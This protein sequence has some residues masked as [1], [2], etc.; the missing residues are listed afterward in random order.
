M[1]SG[2]LTSRQAVETNSN[3]CGLHREAAGQAAQHGLNRIASGFLAVDVYLLVQ[4]HR[5]K[6]HTALCKR[7]M[8]ISELLMNSV[9]S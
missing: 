6:V 9:L 5:L 1:I 3:S 8:W 4:L 7:K 2:Q